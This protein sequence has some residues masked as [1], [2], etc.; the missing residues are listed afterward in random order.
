MRLLIIEDERETRE[1]LKASFEE[2]N[3]VVDSAEDGTS[4]SYMAR[5]NEYDLII[6]DHVLPGKDGFQICEEIRRNGKHVPIIMLSVKSEINH[7][8]H[9][10]GQGI[11]DYVTKP[12][13]FTELLA[14]VRAVL[15]RPREM[16]ADLI[17]VDDLVLDIQKQAIFR[18]SRRIYLTRKEF[19]LL[20]YMMKNKGKVLS[21]GMI[22]EH[23]WNSESDPFSN[24][25]EAHIL[26]LRKKIDAGHKKRLIH[27]VPGRGYKIDYER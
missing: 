9:L 6:L 7:K 21:R 15:R 11:D 24:T 4:G 8:V 22:M 10:F 17:S 20:E 12:F 5:A 1:L 25:I 27:S 23:V 26:N 16:K 18:G 3:F 2:E 13:S 14:R 19:G